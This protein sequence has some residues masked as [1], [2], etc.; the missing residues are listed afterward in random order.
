[1]TLPCLWDR[2]LGTATATVLSG[3]GS[4]LKAGLGKGPPK[5][6]GCW[7]DSVPVDP[8]SVLAGQLALP[9]PV[10]GA[11]CQLIRGLIREVAPAQH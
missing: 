10:R 1:M 5:L 4:L 7:E 8:G 3:L 6:T 11:R 9:V 2:N